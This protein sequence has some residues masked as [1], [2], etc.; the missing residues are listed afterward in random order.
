MAMKYTP[1]NESI[2]HQ[3]SLLSLNKM[4]KISAVD[5]DG[6]IKPRSRTITMNSSEHHTDH[7]NLDHSITID[8]TKSRRGDSTNASHISRPNQVNKTF[9]APGSTNLNTSIGEI[10]DLSKVSEQKPQKNTTGSAL[11]SKPSVRVIKVPREPS[12]DQRHRDKTFS[13]SSSKSTTS[14]SI[15]N[16]SANITVTRIKRLDLG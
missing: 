11:S 7:H 1:F 12:S 3:R 2:S 14:K 6:Y 15:N 9:S 10:D 13:A 5:R 8:E 16:Q 4:N